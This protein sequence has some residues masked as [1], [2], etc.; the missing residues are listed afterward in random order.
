[1]AKKVEKVLMAFFGVVL[2]LAVLV[3]SV[4]LVLEM[5]RAGVCHG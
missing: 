4:A 2:H 3:A 1:M 5:I